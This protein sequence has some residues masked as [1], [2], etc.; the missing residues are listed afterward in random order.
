V[1]TL[2]A[3]PD[4]I[5]GSTFDAWGGA[6]ASSGNAYQCRLTV[7]GTSNITVGF[8]PPGPA[9]AL[10]ISDYLV[11]ATANGDDP[12]PQTVEVSNSGSGILNVSVPAS[13]PWLTAQ[14]STATASK[15]SPATLTLQPRIAGLPLGQRETDVIINS[16][17]GSKSLHVTLQVDKGATIRLSAAYVKFHQSGPVVQI[18]NTGGGTLTGLEARVVAASAGAPSQPVNWVKASMTTGADGRAS[19]VLDGTCYF[20]DSPA[21]ATVEVRSATMRGVSPAMLFVECAFGAFGWIDLTPAGIAFKMSAGTNAVSTQDVQV[22]AS[23][24]PRIA[25]VSEPTVV[26]GM[27]SW[28]RVTC[29]DANCLRFTVRAEATGLAA[30]SYAMPLSVYGRAADGLEYTATLPV[31]LVVVVPPILQLSTK[32]LTFRAKAGS[33][34]AAQIVRIQNGGEH[35][36]DPVSA[37]SIAYTGT[38]IGWL[39][40]SVGGANAPQTLSLQANAATLSPGTYTATVPV[41]SANASNGTQQLQV[42]F[43]VSRQ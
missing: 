41:V 5:D 13:A 38:A 22:A 40:V 27:P 29:A 34:A 8:K 39:S 31:T 43:V 7:S 32:A 35:P 25:K 21:A 15:E 4:P 11:R 17:A 9:L 6:C 3:D 1:L 12:P 16:S 10:S 26:G 19:L 33:S 24:S 28:L 30:G 2:Y 14:L 36:L 18:A 42:T 23:T 37:G 20:P